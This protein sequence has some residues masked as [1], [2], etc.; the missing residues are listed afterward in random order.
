MAKSIKLEDL[1]KEINATFNQYS[2][3]VIEAVDEATW[4]SANKAKNQ[5]I[6]EIENVGIKSKKYKK[7]IS[8]QTQKVG[9]IGT[10]TGIVYVK[11]PH[12]RLSHLLEKGHVIKNQYGTYHR[13]KARPHWEPVQ[14]KIETEY[15][16]AVKEKLEKIK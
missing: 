10:K 5:V 15:P 14:K 11:A 12:Y 7:A 9:R 3:E 4:E 2:E 1:V 16:N 8:A 6:N 13:T